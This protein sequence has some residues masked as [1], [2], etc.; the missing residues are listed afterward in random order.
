MGGTE[1]TVTPGAWGGP[2]PVCWAV[3][4]GMTQ[5][6]CPGRGEHQGGSA[7]RAGPRHSPCEEPGQ[8]GTGALD[9][10]WG[11]ES[12]QPMEETL[13]ASGVYSQEPHTEDQSRKQEQQ[14]GCW[15]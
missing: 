4:G 6:S 14:Q 2:A 5:G 12:V 1:G 3:L 15:A 11:P 7:G 13:P 9:P 8:R 10:G